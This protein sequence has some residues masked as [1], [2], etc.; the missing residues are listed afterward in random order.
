[1]T[2]TTEF[3]AGIPYSERTRLVAEA[4]PDLIETLERAAEEFYRHEDAWQE[5]AARHQRAAG[6]PKRSLE[7][8]HGRTL[9][10]AA[11]A[12]TEKFE[13]LLAAGAVTRRTTGI[14]ER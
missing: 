14:N 7:S 6:M 11:T 1:M 2:D 9:R 5:E 10:Q 8:P 3:A 13:E 12:V 4:R